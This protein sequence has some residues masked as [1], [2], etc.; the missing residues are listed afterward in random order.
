MDSKT[1]D[2]MGLSRAIL[3]NDLLSRLMD[4][5]ELNSQFYKELIKKTQEISKNYFHM[6]E[7]QN[8][9]LLKSFKIKSFLYLSF[10]RSKIRQIFKKS[11]LIYYF[12]N[13]D[14]LLKIN[15]KSQ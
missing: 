8:G 1:A 10:N 12:I 11:S 2:A 3:C 9:K 4:K 14:Y 15:K 13:N 6:S 7:A 5:L